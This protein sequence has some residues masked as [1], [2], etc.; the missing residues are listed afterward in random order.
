MLVVSTVS[1]STSSSSPVDGLGAF[2]FF[3]SE[4]PWG[5]G[6]LV[7]VEFLLVLVGMCEGVFLLPAFAAPLLL[8]P[9]ILQ[10]AIQQTQVFT[11]G[12]SNGWNSRKDFG[13][14]LH[15]EG[16]I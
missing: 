12:V 3:E 11:L 7:L 10:P 6:E 4:V 5:F 16:Q 9:V 13:V 1:T 15:R 8:F 14:L 2:F